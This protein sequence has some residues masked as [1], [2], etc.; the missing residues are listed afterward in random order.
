MELDINGR[1]LAESKET[2]VVVSIRIMER[3][4]KH[5]HHFDEHKKEWVPQP[6][7][8]RLGALLSTEQML[9]WGLIL[10]KEYKDNEQA[11]VEQE[12]REAK[13]KQDLKVIKLPI[14]LGGLRHARVC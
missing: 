14:Y 8:A 12:T 10:N 9:E 1:L 7:A 4:I 5:H 13:H 6:A 11:R 2:G 3:Y